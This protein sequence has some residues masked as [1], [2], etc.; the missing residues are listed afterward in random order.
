MLAT[1]KFEQFAQ[2]IDEI[3]ELPRRSNASKLRDMLDLSIELFEDAK[4]YTYCFDGKTIDL[5]D[6]FAQTSRAMVIKAIE[7]YSLAQALSDEMLDLIAMDMFGANSIDGRVQRNIDMIIASLEILKKVINQNAA[8]QDI[9]KLPKEQFE[10]L[11]RNLIS[12]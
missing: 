7:E 6:K 4:Q 2:D 9:N 12:R 8:L 3:L 11:M 10:I 1:M 5:I